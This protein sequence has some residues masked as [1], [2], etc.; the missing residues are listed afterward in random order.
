[1][2]VVLSLPGM[3]FRKS[4]CPQSYSLI[5]EQTKFENLKIPPQLVYFPMRHKQMERETQRTE[6]KRESETQ[7]KRERETEREREREK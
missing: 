7:R 1:M 5:W 6:A 3:D 4:P 2:Q